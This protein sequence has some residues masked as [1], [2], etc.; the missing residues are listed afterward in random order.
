MILEII[1]SFKDE[2]LKL[3]GAQLDEIKQDRLRLACKAV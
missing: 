3:A 2:I 1:A